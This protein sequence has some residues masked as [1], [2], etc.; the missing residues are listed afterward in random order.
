M[1][2][3]FALYA[4]AAL[5]GSGAASAS[6]VEVTAPL[7]LAQVGQ[8][9]RDV[10][11][12]RRELR[13]ARDDLKDAKRDLRQADTP[14]EQRRALE[15]LR[16]ARRE[17]QEEKRD[18]RE[19]RQ[20]LREALRPEVR[21]RVHR[22]VTTTRTNVVQVPSGFTVATGAVLPGNIVLQA[23]PADIG[24]TQ[25]QYVIIGQQPV[26]VEPAFSTSAQNGAATGGTT[27]SRLP[28]WDPGPADHRGEPLRLVG[29]E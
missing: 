21:T 3:K 27:S 28:A 1:R 14:R 4:A 2:Q 10:R 18:V 16:D 23:F 6:P 9:R 19:E 12:E 8:E 25:Y 29:N 17:V 26:L 24:V 7:Q 11:E 20:E 5:L 15:D 22:Y 13:D